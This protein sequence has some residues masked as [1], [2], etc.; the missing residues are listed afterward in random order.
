[1]HTNTHTLLHTYIPHDQKER[2]TLNS[3]Y[4]LST[5]DSYLHIYEKKYMSRLH[6]RHEQ[7]ICVS[8]QVHYI[9]TQQN[10]KLSWQ[11]FSDISS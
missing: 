11:K 2:N 10:L 6:A 4:T 7:C 1:M 8:G 3:R 9:E 5:S